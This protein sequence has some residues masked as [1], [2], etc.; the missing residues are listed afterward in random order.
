MLLEMVTRFGVAPELEKYREYMRERELMEAE[1]GVIE[2]TLGKEQQPGAGLGPFPGIIP[3]GHRVLVLPDQIEE[4]S[5]GGIVVSIAATKEREEMAQVRGVLIAIGPNAWEEY[6]EPWAWI[7]DYVMFGKYAGA[8]V[9]GNDGK[10]YRLV[11]DLDIVAKIAAPTKP[12]KG[13]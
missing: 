11:N 4:K 5:A 6:G 7:G 3:L 2:S 10:K 1:A 13:T 9:E 8:I 12:P